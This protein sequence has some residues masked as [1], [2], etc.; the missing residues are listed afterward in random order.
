MCAPRNR[1]GLGPALCAGQ[2][3]RA[4]CAGQG[5]RLRRRLRCKHLDDVALLLAAVDLPQQRHGDYFG[6]VFRAGIIDIDIAP[7]AR[8]WAGT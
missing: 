6:E 3:G 1:P 5:A 4:L 8:Q 2:G 7:L